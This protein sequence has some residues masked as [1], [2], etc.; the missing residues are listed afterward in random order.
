MAATFPIK[1]VCTKPGMIHRSRN[2]STCHAS[3]V[4]S[5]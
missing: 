2:A 4:R 3:E 5:T 1:E